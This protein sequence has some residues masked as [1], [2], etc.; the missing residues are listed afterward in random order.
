MFDHIHI[1]LITLK[2]NMFCFWFCK[3]PFTVQQ[4]HHVFFLVP[5]G[6]QTW[7]RK[8][9]PMIGAL[10]VWPVAQVAT[11][12]K[13]CMFEGRFNML[14]A[15]VTYIKQTQAIP[16]GSGHMIRCAKLHLVAIYARKRP[17]VGNSLLIL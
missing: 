6:N 17:I 4:Q 8:I 2:R 9:H 10:G 11:I 16:M 13:Y 12:R 14:K 15:G 1:C 7:Q 5:S 3:E